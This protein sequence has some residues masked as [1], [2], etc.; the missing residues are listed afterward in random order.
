[1]PLRKHKASIKFTGGV[2]GKVDHKIL[3]KEHLV[4]LENGRFD[5]VGAINKRKGYTLTNEACSD[6]VTYKNTLLARNCS[7]SDR[8]AG[9]LSS[10]NIWSPSSAEFVGDVGYSDGIDWSSMPVSRGSEYGQEDSA[11]ALS[12]DGKYACVTFV[13]V[14]WDETNDKKA[15]DV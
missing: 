15:H 2:Q 3:P 1:M 5:K 13:D 9:T 14:S 4:T 12:S 8:S 7:I 6:L 10:G 11:V